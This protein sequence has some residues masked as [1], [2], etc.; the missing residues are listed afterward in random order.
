MSCYNE[1]MGSIFNESTLRG[2]STFRKWLFRGAVGAIIFGVVLGV[3]MILVM[4]EVA[5]A[6]AFGRT[7]GTMFS[8]GIMLIFLNVCAKLIES[9]KA[10]PQIFAII[11]G[12]SSLIWVVFSVISIW[13]PA[14]NIYCSDIFSYN[15]MVYNSPINKLVSIFGYLSLLGVICG[16]IMNMYEG[17]RRDVILPLKI[18]ATVLAA[19]EFI[20]FTVVAIIGGAT[21]GRLAMLAGFAAIVWFV[22]WIITFVLSSSEKKKEYGPYALKRSGVMNPT[23]GEK[24]AASVGK[25]D[26]ELRAEIEEQVRREMIEKEVRAKYEND[27]AKDSK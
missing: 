25:T 18:T 27:R 15:C 24:K 8:I 2:L 20:Y 9:K 4:N 3:I 1:N 10:V 11:G 19:Y 22:V 26:E 14:A 5:G 17:K 7:F 16:A 21:N 13:V 12:I 6:E 23:P